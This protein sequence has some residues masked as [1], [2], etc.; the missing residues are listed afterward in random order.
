MDF[1]FFIYFFAFS[2]FRFSLL[3]SFVM[4]SVGYVLHV[5]DSF[6]IY[7]CSSLQ[8]HKCKRGWCT[9]FSIIFLD[10]LGSRFSYCTCNYVCILHLLFMM[11]DSEGPY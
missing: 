8:C 9:P 7:S 4:S 6:P 10:D 2:F 1:D 3:A 5:S 11:L